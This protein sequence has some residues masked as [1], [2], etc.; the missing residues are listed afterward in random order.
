MPCDDRLDDKADGLTENDHFAAMVAAA[1]ARGFRPRC[2]AF[3]GW[4]SSLD[5][6][7]CGKFV[8]PA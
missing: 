7:Q 2:V 5:S 4:Y 3:D 6:F 8:S 1:H